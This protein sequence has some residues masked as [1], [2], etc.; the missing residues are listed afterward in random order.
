MSAA[1]GL[2]KSGRISITG[3]FRL[4]AQGY[5]DPEMKI[6]ESL[7]QAVGSES[8]K[9]IRSTTPVVI[10]I[11][12]LGRRIADHLAWKGY[13]L[14]IV[15]DDNIEIRNVLSQ[16]FS[17]QEVKL[18]KAIQTAIAISEQC[19]FDIEVE[20]IPLRF[21]EAI[22]KLDLDGDI[23]VASTDS[24]GSRFRIAEYFYNKR[25]VISCGLSPDHNW[26]WIMIQRPGAACLRCA[27]PHE[28]D[29]EPVP[30][31]AGIWTEAASLIA[32]M[33]SYAVDS[34]I[35]GE[36]RPIT[37]NYRVISLPGDYDVVRR[38]GRRPGCELCGA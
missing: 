36:E 6:L 27:F 32:S 31:N 19:P 12:T 5:I 25:P 13:N 3:S 28:E 8:L 17:L 16:R 20:A 37:W 34:L 21:E 22:E 14:K 38:I 4:R 15:D 33:A 7:L 30:C 9:R 35:L 18:N 10:G 11:G 26:G 2:R 23:I 1:K 24:W 29:I